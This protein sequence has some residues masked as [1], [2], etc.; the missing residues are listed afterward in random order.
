MTIIRL[1][2]SH[3]FNNFKNNELFLK[4]KTLSSDVEVFNTEL[5]YHVELEKTSANLDEN[6]KNLLKWILGSPFHRNLLGDSSRFSS[7]SNNQGIIE[8]GPRY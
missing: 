4:L 5:C 3:T 6:Q 8:C 2:D 7:L 1:Y